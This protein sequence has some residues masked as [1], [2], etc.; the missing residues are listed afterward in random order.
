MLPLEFIVDG[1]PV[2]HQAKSRPLW[3]QKVKNAAIAIWGSKPPVEGSLAMTITYLFDRI[4]HPGE[5][6]DVDNVPKPIV[7]ALKELVYPDDVTVT[8]LL[9]RK[10]YLDGDLQIQHLTP[11]LRQSLSRNVEFV[12]IFVDDAPI[13]EVSL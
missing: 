7:D 1:T 6:P 3:Q 13:K 4:G 11:A 12:H 8:D 10:R 2:R 9:C 5:E